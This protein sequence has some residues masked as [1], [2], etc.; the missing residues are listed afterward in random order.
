MYDK[1]H[2]AWPSIPDTQPDRAML[3]QTN[4][5]HTNQTDEQEILRSWPRSHYVTDC[6]FFF[7]VDVWFSFSLLIIPIFSLFLTPSYAYTFQ[8]TR[9]VLL[10]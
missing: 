3:S 2:L 4:R 1:L 9:S 5:E 8:N 10:F 6:S 7:I